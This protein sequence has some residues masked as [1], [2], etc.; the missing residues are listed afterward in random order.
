MTL[1]IF[2]PTPSLSCNNT[3][4]TR[5]VPRTAGDKAS[6]INP[7][8]VNPLCPL[9]QTHDCLNGQVSASLLDIHVSLAS[10]VFV[11]LVFLMAVVGL[12]WFGL[13]QYLWGTYSTPGAMQGDTE[14]GHA[15]PVP[16][17]SQRLPCSV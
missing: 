9:F 10:R 13:N 14:T 6:P 11:Y 17:P 8:Q 7:K 5:E 3:R 15:V 12:L 1:E 2:L 4:P 16:M